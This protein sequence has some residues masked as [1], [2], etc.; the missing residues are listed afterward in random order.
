MLVRRSGVFELDGVGKVGG[1]TLQHESDGSR[2]RCRGDRWC[3]GYIYIQNPNDHPA[4][5]S[6]TNSFLPKILVFSRVP[7]K[8]K[9][10][11]A[12][13]AVFWWGYCCPARSC[14]VSGS[15]ARETREAS[16]AARRASGA[17]AERAC[18]HREHF[19]LSARA[20]TE[21]CT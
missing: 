21:K 13:I 2:P 10:F 17:R 1:R 8:I 3:V 11:S 9:F 19:S 15:I 12:K 16:E 6:G 20:C 7:A 4:A 18:T 14:G 5:G